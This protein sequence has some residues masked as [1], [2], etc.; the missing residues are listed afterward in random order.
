MLV[1]C[2][3]AGIHLSGSVTDEQRTQGLIDE[4]CVSTPDPES[5]CRVEQFGVYRCAQTYAVHATS[6][7]LQRTSAPFG[8]RL[9]F[10]ESS[11][12]EGIAL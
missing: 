3:I 6:M 1:V 11:S 10:L 8:N 9:E 5:A 12:Q 2:G 4:G 7:P